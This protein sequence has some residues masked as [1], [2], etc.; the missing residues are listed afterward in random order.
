GD[1]VAVTI[2]WDGDI[3]ASP[4]LA[5]GWQRIE[6]D[7]PSWS[8]GEHELS[9]ETIPAGISIGNLDLEFAPD[10]RAHYGS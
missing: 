10:N 6:L 2:R 1:D 9:F 3:I 7:F 4:T 5:P 8:V